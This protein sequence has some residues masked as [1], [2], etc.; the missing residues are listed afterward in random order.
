MTPLRRAA[1]KSP[2]SARPEIARD[3]AP[4]LLPAE[5]MRTPSLATVLATVAL[6]A[7][8]GCLDD[9]AAKGDESEVPEDGKLDSFRS[10]TYHGPIGFGVR[11][12]ATLAAPDDRF[13]TWDFTL[14]GP[15]DLV[16]NTLPPYTTARKVDTVL[17]LYRETERGWGSYIARNDDANGKV[18][19]ELRRSLGAGHYRVLVKGYDVATAG[20]FTVGVACTGAGCEPAVTEPTCL[21]G[22]TF[23]EWR[24]DPRFNTYL[25]AK[26]TDAGGLTELE[27]EQIIRAVQES[28]HTDVTT[29]EAAFE[30]VDQH[31][32]NRVERRGPTGD[33][34]TAWEYGAGDNSYGAIFFANTLDR[35]AAIH[36]GDLYHCAYFAPEGGSA[37]GEDCRA[38][39][40]CPA[41]AACRG[42]TSNHGV[43][44][45]IANPAGNGDECD[46]DDACGD[47]L[48]CHG[49][50]RGYGL[51]G[52]AWMRRDFDRT[53][54]LALP[55]GGE[56]RSYLT[57]YGLATVDTDVTVRVQLAHPAP[58]LLRIYL[59]NPATADVLVWDGPAQPATSARLDLAQ[60]V[61]G[62]SGDESVNGT[63]TL[64]VV[65]TGT[66]GAGTLEG[67]GMTIG[68][69]W[70]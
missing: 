22:P 62:F 46:A 56:A 59:R 13:H 60:V 38:T 37:L 65:D 68:S 61:L 7:A 30:A 27:Q 10:P 15:A 64:R 20:R 31:E 11:E 36:D 63:W 9:G 21:L 2:R 28:S 16:M 32:F 29:I 44:A 47:G 26:V 8:P 51:C 70:D 55:S 57:A 24:E 33:I 53:E 50:T 42:I 12:E 14:S 17:Y 45:T 66:G 6:A 52:P 1:V 5:A 35:A 3:L 67:W 48:L 19:S 41:G 49:L 40:D 69:R 4:D 54:A 25:D 43:C 18:W 23:Y 34:L 39:S 58:N